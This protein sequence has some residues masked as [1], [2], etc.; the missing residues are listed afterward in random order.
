MH[1]S[2]VQMGERW[3]YLQVRAA[4]HEDRIVQRNNFNLLKVFLSKW[5][6]VPPPLEAFLVH[7][8]AGGPNAAKGKM[9]RQLVDQCAFGLRLFAAGAHSASDS[10]GTLPPGR[11][12]LTAAPA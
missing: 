3:E 6:T 12:H 1:T 7:I 5:Q 10:L 4:Y 2:A 9:P 11:S 8:T